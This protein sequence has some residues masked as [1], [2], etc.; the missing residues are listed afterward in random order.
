AVPLRTHSIYA[1]YVDSGQSNKFITEILP[2]QSFEQTDLQNR[3]QLTRG[4]PSQCGWLWSRLPITAANWQVEIEFKMGWRYGSQKKELSKV[5][6]SVLRVDSLLD[7][8]LIHNLVTQ[9]PTIRMHSPELWLCLVM[10]TP[11][12]TLAMMERQTP[13]LHA[14]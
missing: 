2:A 13:S 6:S 12:T 14:R 11:N 8:F 10:A 4:V 3:C 9:I 7:S 1:P 5:L